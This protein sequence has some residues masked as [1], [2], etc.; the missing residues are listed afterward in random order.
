MQKQDLVRGPLSVSLQARYTDETVQQNTN[1]FQVRFNGGAVR[2]DLANNTV[3]SSLIFDT[4]FAYNF[5]LSGR[6][7]MRLYLTV[8]NLLDEDPQAL[9]AVLGALN[10]G[11][12]PTATWATCGAGAMHSV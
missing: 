8:N 11:A 3:D 1:I 10:A 4:S 5:D 7:S 6:T 2:Y 12:S 9:Y